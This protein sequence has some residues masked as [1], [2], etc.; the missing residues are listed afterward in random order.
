MVQ[1]LTLE[2]DGERERRWKAE[3]AASRLVEHVRKL[4][5]RVEVVEKKH[6]LAV[7]RGSQLEGELDRERETNQVLQR[8]VEQLQDNA[9]NDQQEK[10]E[11]NRRDEQQIKLL[12]ELEE[13]YHRLETERIQERTLLHSRVRDSET[14]AAGHE[15]ELDI[16]RGTLKQGK[17]EIQQLQELLAKREGEHQR[18]K[19]RC[20]PLDNKEIQDLIAKQV[21]EER[22]K[23][24]ANSNHLKLKLSE[25]EKAYHALEKEFRMGLRIEASRYNELEKAYQEVCGG[26]EATR[27]MAVAAVQKEQRAVAMVEE[28]T[29]IVKEQKVKIKELSCSK[30]ELVAEL[31]ER[32]LGLEAEVADKNKIEARMLSLQEVN[33]LSHPLFPKSHVKYSS[34]VTLLFAFFLNFNL[35]MQ[36]KAKLEPQVAAQQSV[37]DGLREER[38]LWGKELAHQGA[39]L[40]QERGRMEAQLDFLTQETG[41]LRQQLQKERDMVRVKEKQVEDQVHTIQHLKKT[42]AELQTGSLRLEKELQELK[43]KLEQEEASN[44]DLQVRVRH[45]YLK[46][47]SAIFDGH[48]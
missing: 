3:Q 11:L 40:A 7:V 32:L 29:V 48:A 31:K 26:V 20:R 27:K 14:K 1:V 44:V 39:S 34:G 36:E 10:L 43:V 28:L 21:Q 15:R 23:I 22:S 17:S 30:Q 24:E 25:Q 33:Q 5:S 18:E 46:S 35:E 37:I 38:K 12:H 41:T 42:M 13:N 16:L 47:S 45:C 4:Q 8:Q 19:E 6:E 9:S 2:L